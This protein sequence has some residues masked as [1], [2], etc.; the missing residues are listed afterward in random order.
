MS[1]RIADILE[2][3]RDSLS[4]NDK[5]RWTDDRLLRLIDE[6]QKKMAR[7]AQLLRAKTTVSIIG[8]I[9]EYLLPSDAFLLTRVVNSDGE[10]IAIKSHKDMDD[11]DPDWEVATGTTLEF[12]VFDEMNPGYFKTYPILTETDGGETFTL[13]DYGVI[14][15]VEGDVISQDFGV[16]VDVSTNATLTKEFNSV[17]GVCVG[18]ASIIST[19]TVYYRAIPKE[20][21]AIDIAPSELEVHSIYDAAIKHYVIG[22]ALRDDQDTQ[23]RIVGNEELTFYADELKDAKGNSG[24][25]NTSSQHQQTSY[26][27]GV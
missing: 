8:L 18:M 9:N 25:D 3:V 2:R 14:T 5:T 22:T 17:Y 1:T 4:D 27:P 10:K 23:N 6:V 16:C 20:I 7:K 24:K 19:L 26:N 12:I 21:N 11:I 13:T 15:A